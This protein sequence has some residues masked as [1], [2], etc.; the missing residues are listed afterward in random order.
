MM[1]KTMRR[2]R[3][4]HAPDG[5]TKRAGLSHQGDG[6]FRTRPPQDAASR[7]DLAAA[8]QVASG[9]AVI[10]PHLDAGEGGTLSAGGLGKRHGFANRPCYMMTAQAVWTG[11]SLRGADRNRTDDGGFAVL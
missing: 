7:R 9:E 6:R 4:T 11:S 8:A 1:R 2:V 10:G 5:D 3:S